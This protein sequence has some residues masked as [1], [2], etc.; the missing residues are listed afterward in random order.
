MKAII[1]PYRGTVNDKSRLRSNLKAT[2]I[3]KLL[4]HMTQNLIY[5]I[6]NIESSFN[7]YILTKME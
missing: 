7:L 6:S 5:Y 2:S 3:E 1:V 4:Y